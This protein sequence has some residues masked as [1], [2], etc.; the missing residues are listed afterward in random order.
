MGR[1]Q[2][3]SPEAEVMRTGSH[4]SGLGH[5]CGWIAGCGHVLVGSLGSGLVENAE[6]ERLGCVHYPDF[7]FG[8]QP[9]PLQ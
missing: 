6:A 1:C 2:L 9:S 4:T 7:K 8:M 5:V 3:K